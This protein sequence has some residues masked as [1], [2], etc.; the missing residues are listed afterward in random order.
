MTVCG[1]GGKHAYLSCIPWG[2]NYYD[3]YYTTPD[4]KS[5]ICKYGDSN[6]VCA[7]NS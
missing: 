2:S 1:G 6:N 5:K 3:T 4:G 7:A